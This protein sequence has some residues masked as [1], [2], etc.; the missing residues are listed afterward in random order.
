MMELGH[1]GNVQVNSVARP[2]NFV[3]ECFI[4][5]LMTGWEDFG[6]NRS[7]GNGV[8]S[9]RRDKSLLYLAA[10]PQLFHLYAT[11]SNSKCQIK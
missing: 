6:N 2:S 10:N 8:A 1:L 4:S 9:R 5:M 7:M 11:K 3:G